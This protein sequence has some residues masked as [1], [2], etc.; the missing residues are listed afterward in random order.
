M[1]SGSVGS[2]RLSESE[3]SVEQQVT[4]VYVRITNQSKSNLTSEARMLTFEEKLAIL[5]SYPQL[6]R[7]DVSLKR[8]NYHFEDSAYD[9]KIVAYHLHPNG[10]GYIYAG[11]LAGFSTDDKGFVNIREYSAEELRVLIEQSIRSLAGT[12]IEQTAPVIHEGKQQERWIGP[13]D[14]ILTVTYA[15]ELWYVYL[16]VILESA[17]E[18]YEE[19]EL[20]MEEEA[21][22]R[23]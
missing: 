6:Q 11:H 9:K 4:K 19:L 10:N 18:T 8:V 1:E 5:D 3:S 12:G 17:F 21:F 16:G 2:E 22:T 14:H 20:Y 23:L 15:D 7:K 13:D